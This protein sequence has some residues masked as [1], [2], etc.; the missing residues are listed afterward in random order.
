[1]SH[2]DDVAMLPELWPR[3]V[4]DCESITDIGDIALSLWAGLASNADRCDLFA[5]KLL[6]AWQ[7]RQ[8][9]C[10]A[11][12]LGWIVQACTV[13]LSA[14]RSLGTDLK[15]ALNQAHTKLISLFRPAHGLFQRHD[16]RGL[17]QVIGR[18]IACF[19]DQVYPIL[20]LSSYGLQFN[21]RQSIEYAAA[22]ADK[23][24]HVQ[25]SLG[26]WWWHYDTAAG[27]VCEGYPVFSVHQDAM[28]PMALFASDK[29]SGRNHLEKIELGLRWIFGN[30]ELSTNLF[31]PDL[32]LIWRDIERR[33]A[34]KAW[35]AAKALLCLC[36]WQPSQDAIDK[37]QIGF[38]INYECR[39]YH[40][41]WIL[42]AWA[43]FDRKTK[44]A[45][46]WL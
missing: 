8:N 28:A 7:N 3:I 33:D 35:R 22:A 46:N 17:T 45:S 38:R 39:S 13:A 2:P 18:R 24:C 9:R 27:V 20:A 44:E 26:Q 1:M 43:D 23:I 21:D 32:G 30:N 10:S 42:Y 41:G 4:D 6:S 12:E 37:S 25:G 31:Q 14:R 34:A 5:L 19:A 16:R 36:G 40:L 29:A 15:T 11:V